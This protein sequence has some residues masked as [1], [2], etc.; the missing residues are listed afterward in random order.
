VLAAVG[1]GQAFDV[2]VTA[3]GVEASEQ[4]VVLARWGCELAQGNLLGRPMNPVEATRF[5]A[6]DPA[7]LRVR[8]SGPLL[9]SSGSFA[10]PLV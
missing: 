1:A 3:M 10:Q 7:S 2:P 4:R 8:P 6:R 9:R 5:F